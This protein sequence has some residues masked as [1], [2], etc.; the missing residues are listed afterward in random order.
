MIRLGSAACFL[1]LWW[2]IAAWAADRALP[3]PL[4]V[5]RAAAAAMADG[6]LPQA[7]GAT[8]A[9][10]MAAFLL[11][12]VAGSAIGILMG[13][14][15]LADA[16][17]DF[18]LVLLLNLPALVVILLAYIWF[19]QTEAAT[20]IAVALVKLPA[21]AVTLREGA[22]A[23]EPG[24][25]EMAQAYRFGLMARWRD[26]MLPQLHPYLAAAA[27]AGLA[28]AWKIVLVAELLGRPSGV[29]FEMNLRFQVFDVAGLLAYALA[30]A[31]VMLAIEAG[32]MRP[33][34]RRARAWRGLA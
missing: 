13:R 29:G 23:M 28:T 19:G 3:D 17:G 14:S 16:A 5:L 15:R 7:L 18:W 11:A 9:R 31:A 12:M 25:D 10:V 26:V 30:F 34:E 20:V 6:S 22:R 4:T 27:R 2:V 32:V 1:L 21:V 24:L 33:A 8:L